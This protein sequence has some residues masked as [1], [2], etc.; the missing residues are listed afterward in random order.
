MSGLHY[1]S[2]NHLAKEVK[3]LTTQLNVESDPID[4]LAMGH[5]QLQGVSCIHTENLG[6]G[7]FLHLGNPPKFKKQSDMLL[8][9][10]REP[11]T[12]RPLLRAPGSS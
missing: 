7:F 12:P 10:M 4:V 9:T 8:T 2:C 5:F 6:K 11:T 1:F 3:S